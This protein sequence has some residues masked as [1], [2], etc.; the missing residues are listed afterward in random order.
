M[1]CFDV[2]IVARI[3]FIPAGLRFYEMRLLFGLLMVLGTNGVVLWGL[4]LEGWSGPTALALYW[5][6]NLIASILIALRIALHRALTGKR[7]HFRA[8]LGV[9]FSS[10]EG[11]KERGFNSFLPEFLTASIMFT[12]GHGLFLLILLYGVFKAVPDA[13]ALWVGTAGVGLFHVGGFVA[14]LFGLKDR[15]F[16]WIKFTAQSGLGRIV[17]VHFAIMGGMAVAAATGSNTAFFLPFVGLKLLA[18]LGSV[19]GQERR[20][21]QAPGWLVRLVNRLKPGTDFATYLAAENVKELAREAEDEEVV[22]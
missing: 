3:R 6:E 8:Q 22:R 10:G 7:G 15:P 5:F 19:F 4:G 2:G 16:A 13:D 9:K 18:E 14:D 21:Q 20:I 17:L 1:T 11:T 12:L